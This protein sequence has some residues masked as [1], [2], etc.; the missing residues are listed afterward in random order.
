M[1]II[2]LKTHTAIPYLQ[3]NLYLG[4]IK[5]NIDLTEDEIVKTIITSKSTK[6]IDRL[7]AILPHTKYKDSVRKILDE[8]R[9]IDTMRDLKLA[10]FDI[11]DTEGKAY[12]A[13]EIVYEQRDFQYMLPSFTKDEPLQLPVSDEPK[14]IYCSNIETIIHDGTR[15]LK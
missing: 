2:L 6:Y 5:W 11:L 1:D 12:L 15:A 7:F 3:W 8:D 14:T 4:V 9:S 10:L 13:S